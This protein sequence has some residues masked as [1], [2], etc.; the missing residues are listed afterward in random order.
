MKLLDTARRARIHLRERGQTDRRAPSLDSGLD[1][2]LEARFSDGFDTRDLSN[3]K[4]LLG[5]LS[6]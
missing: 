1:D 6:A 3:G 4:A 5:E 2:D